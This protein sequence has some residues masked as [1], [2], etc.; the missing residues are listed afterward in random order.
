ML[1]LLKKAAALGFLLFMVLWTIGVVRTLTLDY[2][3]P[4]PPPIVSLS[5]E[6][7]QLQRQNSNFSANNLKQIGLISTP[8]PLVLDA[9]E[10]EKVRITD[11][12]AYLSIVT[13]AF[14]E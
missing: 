5:G 13:T 2:S 10:L 7:D 3:P 12:T 11:K 9:P 8:L 6:F 1:H 14:K 4:P